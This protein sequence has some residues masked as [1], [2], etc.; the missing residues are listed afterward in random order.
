[1]VVTQARGAEPMLPIPFEVVGRMVETLDTVTL[2]LEPRGDAG[3]SFEPGQF[4]M[5][6]A[7]GIG[8]S[9]ISIAGDPAAPGTFVHT[10]RSVG[11]VTSALAGTTRGG[12]VGVR[13]PYGTGWPMRDA[14]GRDVVVVAGG[15]GLAPLRPAVL[16]LLANRADFGSILLVYGARTPA[17]LLYRVEV[18]DWLV[19]SDVAAGV[20]VDRADAGW[21]GDV[22]FVTRTLS[23]M[24]Q[25]T[26]RPVM[27]VCGPEIMMRSV[28]EMGSRDITGPDDIYLSF[29]RNMKCGIGFCGHCQYG[30]DFL[31]RQGPVLSYAD[32]IDRLEVRDL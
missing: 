17:D 26:D 30:P 21:P 22:G 1:M 10:I 5:V 7:F 12:V 18:E 29:E 23:R 3:T 32:V 16:H 8:E 14:V 31:C 28:A 6:S 27:M 20:T 25:A 2:E 19:R 4:N 11:A 9:A 13:G 15:I 24:R